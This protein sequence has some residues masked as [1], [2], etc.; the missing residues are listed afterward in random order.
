ME[1]AKEPSTD[2]TLQILSVFTRVVLADLEGET[3]ANSF[4]SGMQQCLAK[5]TLKH[6]NLS[7]A[8]TAKRN[9]HS[10][11]KIRDESCLTLPKSDSKFLDINTQH[12]ERDAV[13]PALWHDEVG[14][15]FGGLNK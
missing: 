9:G 3:P 1:I 15:L 11:Q 5:L 14:V 6:L 7:L 12:L 2:F 8:M 4:S 13:T 10:V